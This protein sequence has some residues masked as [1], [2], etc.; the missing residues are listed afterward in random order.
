V[1]LKISPIEKW[2]GNIGQTL[3]NVGAK[4]F[5]TVN[6]IIIFPVGVWF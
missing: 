1:N 5:I 2:H 6:F 4:G 3:D